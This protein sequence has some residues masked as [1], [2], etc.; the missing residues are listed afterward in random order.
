MTPRSPSSVTGSCLDMARTGI[1]VATIS[2]GLF[3]T[4]IYKS[5]AGVEKLMEEV[6]FPKRFGR[7][8]EF[9]SLF[10]EVVRNSMINGTTIRI[11]G[12]VRF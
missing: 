1:R 11:D 10:L 7:A 12:A 9:A 5:P 4:P 2:P 3:L 8:D 6:V